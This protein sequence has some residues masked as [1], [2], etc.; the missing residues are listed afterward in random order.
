MNN[1]NNNNRVVINLDGNL[2]DL[3]DDDITLPSLPAQSVS[4]IDEP[5]PDASIEKNTQDNI[6]Q[7]NS[8]QDNKE[9]KTATTEVSSADAAQNIALGAPIV[10]PEVK[11]ST[12]STVSSVAQPKNVTTQAAIPKMPLQEQLGDKASVGT[13]KKRHN[14]SAT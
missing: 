11:T 12:E 5:A 1:P 4:I 2:D 10:S 13:K 9:N 3:D 8:G 6:S 7:T 14:V